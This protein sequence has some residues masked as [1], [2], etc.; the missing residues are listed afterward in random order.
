MKISHGLQMKENRWRLDLEKHVD[1]QH[2]PSTLSTAGTSGHTEAA[3]K[4]YTS[5]GARE[6]LETRILPPSTSKHAKTN[7]A[8]E[9][10]LNSEN[11]QVAAIS[12]N[13][14]TQTPTK[15]QEYCFIC[16]QSLKTPS[17]L[18]KHQQRKCRK[19]LL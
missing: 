8:S 1:R 16:E 13:S 5:S 2:V 7:A 19:F 6:V 9:K 12:Q 3:S 11:T 15:S 18:E 4:K 14:P 17:G 10:N